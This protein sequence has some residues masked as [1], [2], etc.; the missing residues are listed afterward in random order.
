MVDFESHQLLKPS[1]SEASCL[2]CSDPASLE[3]LLAGFLFT[4]TGL[5][6]EV[7]VEKVPMEDIGDFLRVRALVNMSVPKEKLGT[8]VQAP[9]FDALPKT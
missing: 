5:M 8:A 1:S 9:L 6:W 7:R 2:R 3:P 4:M